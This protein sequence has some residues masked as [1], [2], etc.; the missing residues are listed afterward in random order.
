M[1]TTITARYQSAC[2]DCGRTIEIGET[3]NYF[4]RVG[5]THPTCAA[6]SFAEQQ[7][8]R[9]ERAGRRAERFAGYAG[10]AA[11][12]S[13]A[14]FKKADDIADRI[15]LGQPILVGHHSERHARADQARIHDGMRKGIDEGKRA[16]SWEH[17]AEHNAKI[18]E[19]DMRHNIG[20]MQRRIEDAEVAIRKAERELAGNPRTGNPPASGEWR[21]HI[22][23]H[24]A[25]TIERRDYWRGLMAAKG[26]TQH[27]KDTIKVGDYVRN[28]GQWY[29]V[30]RVS[31][32]SVSVSEMMGAWR[33]R[34]TIP[35]A[36]IAEHRAAEVA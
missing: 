17:R 8:A 31:P 19:G 33:Y 7:A 2:L 12:A 34:H 28:R 25:E 35:Y 9:A 30:E 1:A 27:S 14:A 3:I 24:L 4:R 16:E 26:G 22:E 15:P 36:E 32:K 18:A 23:A 20:F 29:K 6:P 21:A 5:A 11:A 13:A 10:S